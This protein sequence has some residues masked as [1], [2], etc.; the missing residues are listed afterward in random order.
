ML[1]SKIWIFIDIWSNLLPGLLI[2]F[3]SHLFENK[4]RKNKFFIIKILPLLFQP[5]FPKLL[6]LFVSCRDN[7][8]HLHNR[9][10]LAPYNFLIDPSVFYFSSLLWNALFQQFW[11]Q[12]QYFLEVSLVIW[13]HLEENHILWGKYSVVSIKIILVN[14]I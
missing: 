14:K 5:F 2:N 12:S 8:Q 3:K 6:T 13:Y 4:I 1:S 9:L 7:L 10:L 11:S